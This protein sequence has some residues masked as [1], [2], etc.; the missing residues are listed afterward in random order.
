MKERMTALSV[1]R[2]AEA[3]GFQQPRLVTSDVLYPAAKEVARQL[4][5]DCYVDLEFEP[6]EWRVYWA[7]KE[8]E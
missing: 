8:S 6:I 2:A 5:F 1:M 4:G 7:G 3:M